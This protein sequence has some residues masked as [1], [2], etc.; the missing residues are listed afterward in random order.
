MS[1]CLRIVSVSL[2]VKIYPFPLYLFFTGIFLS[3]N[4]ERF[5]PR[6]YLLLLIVHNRWHR[7]LPEN[8][9][10]FA[11]SLSLLYCTVLDWRVSAWELPAFHFLSLFT[12]SLSIWLVSVYL[13]IVAFHFSLQSIYS[14]PTW[15]VSISLLV[16]IYSFTLYFTGEFKPAN[17]EWFTSCYNL[18][19]LPL[20]DRWVSALELW[21][22]HFLLKSTPFPLYLFFTGNYLRIVS[23]LFLDTIYS[24]CYYITGDIDNCL[25]IVRVLL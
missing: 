3:E 11:P 1:V 8:C 18:F 19:L 6:H 25:K 7:Q 16:I 5:V 17:C 9:E 12:S 24:F 14:S 10:S 15:L 22:F 20:L 4:C 23:V 21:A 13:R 2:L